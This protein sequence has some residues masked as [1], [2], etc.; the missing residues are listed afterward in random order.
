MR[1]LRKFRRLQGHLLHVQLDAV[2]G[3]RVDF[4]VGLNCHLRGFHGEF[5][6][7]RGGLPESAGRDGRDD[8]VI[9]GG[10]RQQSGFADVNRYCAALCIDWSFLRHGAAHSLRGLVRRTIGAL[11]RIGINPPKVA[12]KDFGGK[13]SCHY[14]APARDERILP[15]PDIAHQK[16]ALLYMAGSLTAQLFV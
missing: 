3:L 7:W 16:R 10:S 14:P 4:R 12:F 2:A 5:D 1:D 8:G 6:R 15:L 9:V 13:H 11:S